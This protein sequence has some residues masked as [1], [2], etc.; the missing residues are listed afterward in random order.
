[1][2]YG[3]KQA[4]PEITI[5]ETKILVIEK[6]LA[7]GCDLRSACFLATQNPNTM[8]NWMREGREKPES[9]YGA[10]FIRM[11]LAVTN[12]EARLLKDLNF[13]HVT[14]RA[15]EYIDK[16]KSEKILPDGTILKEYIQIK[17]K[18][19]VKPNP[20]VAQ[21][22]MSR[23]FRAKWGDKLDIQITKDV[24]EHDSNEIVTLR[25]NLSLKEENE[26]ILHL[27]EQLKMIG[28]YARTESDEI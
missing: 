15:A 22:L 14:G 12:F 1:M 8:M 18:E 16:L 27:A 4:S 26:N 11:N 21:W 6:W 25:N 20:L 13:V 23:R 7:M 5:D 19:E 9:V 10:L 28:E 17:V 3:Q 2:S 24:L